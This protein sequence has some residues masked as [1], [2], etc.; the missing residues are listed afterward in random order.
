[1]IPGKRL[2]RQGKLSARPGKG[3]GAPGEAKGTPG[4]AK[5]D[6]ELSLFNGLHGRS[7]T[8]AS[9]FAACATGPV[10]EAPGI[11]STSGKATAKASNGSPLLRT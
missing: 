4:E 8:F 3:K 10:P 1:M 9:A 7:T 5:S 6:R 11:G 2:E